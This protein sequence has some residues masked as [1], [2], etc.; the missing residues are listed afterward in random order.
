VTGERDERDSIHVLQRDILEA[1]AL[2]KPLAEVMDLLCRRAELLAPE[3]LCSVLL[4]ANGRLHTIAAPSLSPEYLAALEGAEIG[5]KAG[6]CG[7]AAW[8]GEH[9]EVT[10]I[11][12]DPLWEGYQDLAALSQ[13]SACWST[14]IKDADGSVV[15][16]FAIYYR[17]PRGAVGFHRRMVEACVHLCT[18]A[19]Q[20]DRAKSK[21]HHLAFYDQLTGLPNRTL[22]GDRADIALALANSK[23]ERVA[24]MLLD[25]DRFKTIN[26][27]LGYAVGDRF[28]KEVARRL[29]VAVPASDTVCRLGGDEFAI[30]LNQVDATR[31]AETAEELLSALYERLEI[32]GMALPS[33][34]S[35]GISMYPDD[36]SDFDALLKNAEV[37]MYHAKEQGRNRFRF[38]KSEM[39]QA[40]VQR[41]EM[42]GA[43]RRAILNKEFALDF[44][45]QVDL[46]T[47]TLYGVEALV[48]WN[49]PQWGRV[50]P[51]HFIP[52]AEECGLI[53]DID[54]WVLE[55]TCRQLSTWDNLGV[56]VP[57]VAVNVS[58]TDFEQGNIPRRVTAALTRHGIKGERLIL[59]ITER[60]M[61]DRNEN[62]L[63]A[64][65]ALR[66]VG[67]RISVD[68]FGTGYS[69]LTYLKR[70]PV[71]ELKLD[72]S[73]VSDLPH[74]TGD[75]ALAAAVIRVGQSLG[76]TVVAEG[77]ENDAQLTFLRAQ[78]CNVGQ[79]F[80]F[81][82]PFG[83]DELPKW[84]D[85][86]AASRSSAAS[87]PME[88]H[89]LG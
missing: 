46:A 64:F 78:G 7:T 33:N 14:P 87:S 39:D 44:Q 27:S 61:M 24:V 65:E 10:D 84:L 2:G 30:L 56:A 37:A 54:T 32:D 22:L 43:I 52:L 83:A 31:A 11:F 26:D 42:E 3:M 55:E 45:P 9:V 79:G 25:I 70:F 16:T 12:N 69:S 34:A 68:D 85:R 81:S 89:F 63:V 75:Q 47:H 62:T 77:V 57:A 17:T 19:I 49:H 71:S 48:R 4:V 86:L 40:V 88:R 59:E 67:V 74:D 23:G 58:A 35:I 29:Q 28:L 5:P 73:F 1:V 50:P 13:V 82:E 38:F 20:N 51:E 72:R 6:S 21:I 18:I 76:L 15:A 8:R 41:L 66:K 53:N 60:L 80:F 36:A